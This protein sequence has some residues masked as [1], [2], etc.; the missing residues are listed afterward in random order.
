MGEVI[1]AL[2]EL[3]DNGTSVTKAARHLGIGRSTACR[4]IQESR[5][6][7]PLSVRSSLAWVLRTKLSDDGA[8]CSN[9][10]FWVGSGPDQ[11]RFQHRQIGLGCDPAGHV[12]CEVADVV[13]GRVC[14][15]VP[16]IF[17]LTA[18]TLGLFTA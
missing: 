16:L 4:V 3:V 10:A 11:A 15:G 2:Q 14:G 12:C 7:P 6:W 1:P 17:C 9:E 18:R 5:T 8:N 13:A